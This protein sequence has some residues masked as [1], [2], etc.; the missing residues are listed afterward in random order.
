MLAAHHAG[1]GLAGLVEVVGVAA[2]AAQ[3]NGILGAWHGL[4]DAIV[5]HCKEFGLV[6]GLHGGAFM[7]G[8]S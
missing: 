7:V 5:L 3:K 4:T 8:N 1:I 2:F 6:G